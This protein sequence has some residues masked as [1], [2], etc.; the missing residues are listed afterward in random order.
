MFTVDV[1]QQYNNNNNLM[2]AAAI[3]YSTYAAV[4]SYFMSVAAVSY[5]MPAAGLSWDVLGQYA[6]DEGYSVPS[7]VRTSPI[8]LSVWGYGPLKKLYMYTKMH[9]IMY[10]FIF[11]E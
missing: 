10:Q 6:S 4:I 1:K 8:F 7:E 3:S 2:S 11:P 9:K 5:L